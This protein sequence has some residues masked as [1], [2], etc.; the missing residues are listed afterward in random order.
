MMPEKLHIISLDVDHLSFNESLERV[1]ALAL[2]KQ[3]SFIC[4][5]NVHMTIE[6]YRDKFFQWQLK[7]ADLVLADGKPI[8]IA[9]RLLHHKKQDRISG[10]DFTP[11]ILKMANVNKVSVFFYGSTHD[12][13]E[14][15]RE[16]IKTD[17]PGIHF[18]GALSPPF[19]PL[20]VTEINNDIEKIN[21]S[22]AQ[23]VFVSLGCPRQEKWMAENSAKINS[24]LLGIGGALP[25]M[26]GTQKRAPVWMQNL[27]LEWLYRLIQQPRR[28]FFRY[29]YTNSY[30]VVLLM[31]EWVKSFFRNNAGKT[32]K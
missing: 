12:V 7:K 23:I 19:R 28:L 17:Y 15:M 5:A 26:A 14:L 3:S 11:R 4:F 13:L 27:S 10:M 9:C 32:K 21:Q 2:S 18:A 24:V 31:S 6:A 25:V 22:G 8:A 30:F 16:K 20:S 1:I 29:L